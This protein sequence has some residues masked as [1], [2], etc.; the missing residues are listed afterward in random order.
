[1]AKISSYP[2]ATPASGDLIV[3]TD[4]TGNVTKNFTVGSIIDLAE[5]P[6]NVNGTVNTIPVFTAAKAIGDSIITQDSGANGVSVGGDVENNRKFKVHGNSAVDGNLYLSGDSSAYSIE[7]GQSRTTEGVALLDLTGEII[8]DDY[9]L[10]MIRYA[11]ENAESAII[12]TGTSNLRI[13]T[14]DAADTVFENTKVGIGT[15]TPSS[16]LDVNGN[17]T[18]GDI[19]VYNTGTS[20]SLHLNSS[21]TASGGNYIH[22]KKSDNSNQWVLGS[23][24]DS[25]DRVALKQ[26]NDA[27]I[28]FQNNSGDAM[29]I[30]SNGYV[31]IGTTS[32]NSKL[33]VAGSIKITESNY[34]YFG[35]AGSI[36]EWSIRAY[37][38][39]LQGND[40]VIADVANTTAAVKFENGKGVVLPNKTTTEI[41]AISSPDK[42]AMV[43]NT[44]LNTICFYN[45]SVWQ[46]VSHANM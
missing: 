2:T 17:I 27:N 3:G 26:Y 31:G 45:G 42:G 1:M 35:G 36:P 9:G 13:R 32:P 18:S 44:T 22:A 29:T 16:K 34:L 12:H 25:D 5:N 24:S 41:N 40:L 33:E 23:N 14:E 8:P 30:K 15:T 39:G 6:D 43:Y 28:V 11:G 37:N 19:S 38:P 46:K 21:S 10:R 4:I 7:V 20:A